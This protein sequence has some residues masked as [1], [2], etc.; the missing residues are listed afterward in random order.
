MESDAPIER[1]EDLLVPFV[2]AQKTEER[3]GAEMEK[4][5][6]RAD[7][8]PI[9]YEGPDGVLVFLNDLIAKGWVP[10]SEYEG[11][12]VLS[13]TKNGGS[14]T[15]EPGSQFELSGAQHEDVHAVSQEGYDHLRELL[16]LSEKLGVQWLGLGFHPYAKRSDFTFVPKLRY[17]IMKE[18]L[19]TRGHYALDMML[20]TSTVQANFDYRSEAD[21]MRKLRVGLWL[22]PLNAAIFA[23]SPFVEGERFGGKS[24]RAK[25][26]LDVDND[27]SGLVPA[28]LG[29]SAGYTE[30]VEWALSV[31][32]FL[33]KRDG[34]PIK[35]TGQ[36]FRD[37]WKNGFDGHR[38]MQ[39]DWQTHINTLFPE[40]RLKRT[41]EV[42]SADSQN[43]VFA[44]ALS[45]LW[46]GIFYDNSALGRAESL[47][48]DF[49]FDEVNA[50]RQDVWRLGLQSPWRGKTLQPLAESLLEIAMGGLARRAKKNAK[51]EDERVH[52]APLVALVEKGL[53]PSDL[54]KPASMAPADL[55]AA[56]RITVD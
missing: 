51:G 31:P 4:F 32:M 12:P 46:T 27:R 11:G 35:N 22:S 5:G 17:G 2:S 9:Q 47:V 14:I 44:P 38:A 1:Y 43:L 13:L 56:T 53:S 55:I 8:S 19:P 36:T 6:V 18:Y 52:L 21:A 41:I 45:A 50:V 48:A 40:V 42:R 15:L 3:I 28:V 7:G 54:L 39:S 10:D 37:F 33:I 30:Y 49:T 34:R 23:N 20:R 16:P 29:K 24:Y 26:W 25:V